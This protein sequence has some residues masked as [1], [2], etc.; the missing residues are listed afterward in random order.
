[1]IKRLILILAITWGLFFACSGQRQMTKFEVDWL[2]SDANRLVV[3][4][5]LDSAAV[6]INEAARHAPRDT[7]I[8][9]QQGI[10][11]RKLGTV[12]GRRK[13]A[14]ALRELVKADRMN[15]YYRVELAK[16]LLA[17][18]FALEARFQLSLAIDLDSSYEEAYL[19]M[20]NTYRHPYFEDGFTEDADSAQEVLTALTRNVPRSVPGLVKLAELLAIR[21]EIDSAGQFADSALVLDSQSVRANLAAGYVRYRQQRFIDAGRDFRQAFARMDT[22]SLTPYMFIRDLLRPQDQSTYDKFSAAQKDSFATVYWKSRDF[23]PT[24]KVNERQVEHWARVWKAN[25]LFSNE[26]YDHEGWLTDMGATLIRLGDPDERVREYIHSGHTSGTPAW[27]WR[28]QTTALPCTL[29]FV[30]QMLSG[31]YY[32]SSPT[33]DNTGSLRTNNSRR[34]AYLNYRIQPEE[35][36]VMRQRDE[37]RFVAHTYRFFDSNDN[38]E[39]QFAALYDPA[40]GDSASPPLRQLQ[41]RA[42]VQDANYNILQT[43]AARA[44]QEFGP[45]AGGEPE[46]GSS[47]R[48]ACFSLPVHQGEL[49]WNVVLEALDKSAFGRISDTL[50]I[51]TAAG[52]TLQLSDI[53]VA[54]RF[55]DTT[56]AGQPGFRRRDLSITPLLSDTVSLH[57]PLNLYFEIYNLPIDIRSV[58]RYELTYELSYTKSA[59][60]GLKGLLQEIWPGKKESVSYTYREGGRETD[61][62]RQLSL[63]ITDLRPGHYDLTVTVNDLI[64]GEKASERIGLVLLP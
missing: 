26:R 22:F 12:E 2:V 33:N 34:V 52:T 20:A 41:L 49:T 5:D 3:L 1:M 56:A 11:N 58:T 25:L 19:L 29:V 62:Q 59:A 30:D 36:Q 16:T 14:Q 64:M 27:Y 40:G 47:P 21:G 51:P 35:S 18:T 46:I 43:F 10:I 7:A 31:T 61:R 45:V 60:T 39:L 17:Q 55:G 13:S 32:F 9:R 48:L 4:D 15:P 28:Y 53:V 63:D 54:G 24:T 44:E 8:L 38:P 6:V 57:N 37:I 23:D 50:S 42:S